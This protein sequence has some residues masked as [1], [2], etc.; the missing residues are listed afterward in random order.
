MQLLILKLFVF[1]CFFFVSFFF[2]FE[3]YIDVQRYVFHYIVEGG[4]IYLCMVDQDYSRLLSFQ[5]LTE[6]KQK[7]SSTT[8]DTKNTKELSVLLQSIMD[9]YNNN[10]QE[11]HQTLYKEIN[12]IKDVMSDNIDKLLERG[13]HIELLVE[14][15]DRLDEHTFVFNKRSG[16]LKKQM[17]WANIKL[18]VLGGTALVVNNM[19]YIFNF[20]FFFSLVTCFLF[21]LVTLLFHL[22]LLC[23]FFRIC[24][25]LV[26]I[27]LFL[28][29]FFLLFFC[30]VYSCFTPFVSFFPLIHH[31][32]Q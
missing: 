5:Y 3:F 11:K 32:Y 17:L 2:L 10:I 27:F 28:F 29:S 12:N 9:K 20:F 16:A 1:I 4:I 14:K 25:F 30:F 13:E 31:A 21:H 18:Y 15:T 23:F 8:I 22:Y 6:L 7:M 24:L 26:V 19:D